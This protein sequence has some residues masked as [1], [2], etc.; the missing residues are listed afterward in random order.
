MIIVV[1]LDEA[2]Y[3][4]NLGPLVIGATVWQS[5]GSAVPDFYS[6]LQPV[7]TSDPRDTTAP[8]LIA[9]SKRVYTARGRGNETGLP[10]LERQVLG[11]CAAAGCYTHE[12]GTRSFLD[13]LDR[14]GAAQRAELPWYDHLDSQLPVATTLSQIDSVAHPLDSMLRKRGIAMLGI[15]THSI[16]PAAFNR[17][18]DTLGTKGTVLSRATLHLAKE[19]IERVIDR[20][21]TSV[22]VICDKHGGRNRY[23]PFLLDLF[24]PPM[25]QTLVES[26]AVSSYR[27][28][29]RHVPVTIE[30]R[31]RGEAALPTALASMTAKYQREISMR[32][33][34]RYWSVRQKN[35]KPTAGYPVDAKRFLHDIEPELSR[36]PIDR[37]CLWRV[38]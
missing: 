22:H 14:G 24:G 21:P 3:G 7:V 37:R 9:D 31:A 28:T 11:C 2:G 10:Q 32:A 34:N 30:F 25:I 35:L 1:G 13:E 23:A 20:R 5:S 17:S 26:T 16:E 38:R 36:S 4:P 29:F 33:F 6:D 18:V 12:C 19:Q 15:A 8:V 27:I